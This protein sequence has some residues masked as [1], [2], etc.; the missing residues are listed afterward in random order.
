MMHGMDAPAAPRRAKI[1][2]T[3]GPSSN[4]PETIGELID[5]GMNVARLNFSHGDHAAHAR[6]Y[7]IV[8]QQASQRRKAVAIFADLQ[9]PKL[10][11][12][13]IPDG[14][15]QLEVGSTV[16]ISVQPDAPV[17]QRGDTTHITTTFPELC[18][19]VQPDARIL[20]ND[21]AMELQV[22]KTA[23]TEV[24]ATVT[25]G[26]LL[27]S[28][29]GINLPGV[30]MD[31]D[32]LTV[33]DRE[34][35]AFALDLGVDAIAL[36]FVRSADDIAR[37]RALADKSGRRVPLIAKIEKPEAVHNLEAIL[38]T[39]DGIMVA[40]GD[41]GVEVGPEEVPM[42]QKRVIEEANRR[43]KLVITATQ[44][45]ESMISHPRPTR[46]EASD[47]ANAVLD[48]TDA[49]MLSGE[50]AAGAHPIRVVQ[51]MD[52][53]IRRTEKAPRHWDEETEDLQLGHTANAIARAAVS[54]SESL[55][56]SKAII[57]YTG[58]GGTAR[59]VS[60]YR[61]RVPIFALTPNP[62]TYQSLAMYWGVTPMLFSPSSPGGETIFT[63]IDHAV[64]AAGV[65]ERGDRVVI[66]FGYP[67]R[68]HTSVNLL[69]L[70]EVG[71]T[72]P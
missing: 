15:F 64:L 56:D 22:L 23:E 4:S 34:D 11:V 24:T 71:E 49:V 39:T 18:R 68:A 8:R 40:R 37:A 60:E 54:S 55:D 66:T 45:L 13:K 41:L 6:V 10:R 25:I 44:M 20:L 67:L 7:E 59:L 2:C 57:T 63:D 61:P 36:S 14:G 31:I 28:N 26:G 72:L 69:K 65:L 50:T 43:G 16:V 35:L 19:A 46:A 47:V 32:P 58:S 33:K 12:G 30:T 17:E 27:T 5:A 21:G 29:K 48:G 38:D 9:G 42:L 70:H 52:R 1:V 62:H 53:I 3:L 51:T